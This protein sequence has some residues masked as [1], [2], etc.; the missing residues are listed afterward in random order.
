LILKSGVIEERGS[1][2]GEDQ[3]DDTV[4]GCGGEGRADGAVPERSGE[5]RADGAVPGC[6]DMDEERDAGMEAHAEDVE[7]GA[8]WKRTGGGAGIS[9][10]VA[11]K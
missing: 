1:D 11:G 10:C 7:E 8:W 4:L 6:F 3:V 9:G 2:G 5:G